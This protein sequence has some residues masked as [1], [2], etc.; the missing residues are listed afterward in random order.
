MI[1]ALALASAFA[2]SAPSLEEIRE[3]ARSH[4]IELQSDADAATLW[5]Q[6]WAAL[7]IERGCTLAPVEVLQGEVL[8]FA[9]GTNPANATV[10]AACRD[11]YARLSVEASAAWYGLSKSERRRLKLFSPPDQ[12][13]GYDGRLAS[14]VGPNASADFLLWRD[15]CAAITHSRHILEVANG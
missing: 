14:R 9:A 2:V 1:A 7:P 5:P 4:S 8:R 10:L 13:A 6:D 3:R 15:L 11:L 12:V